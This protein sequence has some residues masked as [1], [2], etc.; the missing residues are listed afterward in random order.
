MI[1]WKFY[2]EIIGTRVKR[3]NCQQNDDITE[4][5]CGQN[6]CKMFSFSTKFIRNPY[7]WWEGGKKILFY[8]NCWIELGC[9]RYLAN[10]ISEIHSHVCYFVNAKNHRNRNRMWSLCMW[11]SFF[12]LVFCFRE[13]KSVFTIFVHVINLLFF[14]KHLKICGENINCC[15][16]NKYTI[17]AIN[18]KYNIKI[19]WRCRTSAMFVQ[20]FI[21][22][23]AKCIRTKSVHEW[24]RHLVCVCVCISDRCHIN[25]CRYSE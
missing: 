19:M 25:F 21:R 12:F 6:S 20:M 8:S 14:A 24:W 16:P 11:Y 2:W 10:A 22:K 18:G 7:L 1:K 3:E 13:G 4:I 23:N 9:C 5:I 15:A 17:H